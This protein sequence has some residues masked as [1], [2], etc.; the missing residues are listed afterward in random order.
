[1]SQHIDVD[2]DPIRVSKSMG[3]RASIGPIPA[4]LLFP[5]MAI[6]TVTYFVIC[7]MLAGSMVIW[8]GCWIWLAGT[9]WALAGKRAYRFFKQWQLPPGHDWINGDALFVRATDQGLWKRKRKERQSAVLMRTDE[10]VKRFMPFQKFCH[11]HSIAEVQI[12]GHRFACLLLHNPR[13]DQWSAQIPFKLTGL[14]PQL[15]RQ[16][17]EETIDSLRRGLQELPEREA[18]TF[19]LGCSTDIRERYYQLHQLVESTA[20]NPISVLLLN[21][22]KRIYELANQGVRQVWSQSVWATWTAQRSQEDK[23]D[24]I[25]KALI[26][27][28]NSLQKSIRSFVGTEQN[29]FNNF[30]RNMMQQVYEQGYLE[31]RNLLET[32]CALEIAPMSAQEVWDWLWYRFNKSPAPLLSKDQYIQIRETERGLSE[33]IP[34]SGQKDLI[35]LLIQGEKGKTSVPRHKQQ[36]GYIYLNEKVGKVVVLEDELDL[37]ANEFELCTGY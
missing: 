9:Y 26:A 10:G 27:L 37:D 16:E 18:L 24:W 25:G 6:G 11:L 23:T 30:Y 7:M 8:A 1:M 33:N 5:W 28:Q 20:L 29:Y 17:V 13:S 12:G 14:H 31:W 2:Q 21:E 32:K 22:Q 4:D 19:Y 34:I 15:Y 3:K 36:H 35:T